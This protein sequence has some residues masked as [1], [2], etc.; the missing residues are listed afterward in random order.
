MNLR[1]LNKYY[2]FHLT[3]Y[4]DVCELEKDTS[5]FVC[6]C[7]AFP[8]FF[9]SYEELVRNVD[10][11]DET[12]K[13]RFRDQFKFFLKDL[14]CSQSLYVTD[15]KSETIIEVPEI[16]TELVTNLTEKSAI[17][18]FIPDLRVVMIGHDDYGFILVTDIKNP[19]L[20]NIINKLEQ[21]TLY[22]VKPEK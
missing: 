7:S 6:R 13:K 22:L 18:L 3:S 12:T 5:L 21:Y 11:I 16:T 9:I 2:S 4:I 20:S 1:E 14:L 15:M 8:K 17:N 10:S 19:Y